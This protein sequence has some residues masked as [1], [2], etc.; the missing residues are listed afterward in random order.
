[1]L[2]VG[3]LLGVLVLLLLIA[4]IRTVL[5]PNL[6]STY[7][8]DEPEAVSLPLAQKLSQIRGSA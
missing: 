5:T 1:M 4:L 8:A 3:I 7:V 6:K 2:Y